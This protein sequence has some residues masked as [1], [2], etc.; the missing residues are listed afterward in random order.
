MTGPTEPNA[1]LL[2][3]TLEHIENRPEEWNQAHWHCG[4]VAC[5]AGHAAILDGGEWLRE[6]PDFLLARADDPQR[7]VYA[8]GG[9]S[10]VHASD[11]AQRILGL[12]LEQSE[13]LFD[14]DSDL[15]DLRELVALIVESA[16]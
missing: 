1:P 4:T 6:S 11:R 13:D 3:K 8:V 5:F 10:A 7:D 16:S 9:V 15:D 2:L 12:T 14:G